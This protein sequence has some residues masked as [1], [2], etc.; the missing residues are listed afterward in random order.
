MKA[1]YQTFWRI[2]R[3]LNSLYAHGRLANSGYL[4]ILPIDQGN[5]HKA[6][7]AFAQTPYS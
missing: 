3:S 5:E 6:G 4:S 1:D 2:L 7:S